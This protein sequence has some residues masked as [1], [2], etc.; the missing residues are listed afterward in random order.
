M[1]D[2][3]RFN[4]HLIV[5]RGIGSICAASYS[6]S[7]KRFVKATGIEQPTKDDVINYLMGF[8]TANKSYSHITNTTLALERYMEFLGTPI[9]LGRPHKPKRIV[10]GTLTEAE[11]ARMF[12]V[13]RNIR[14]RALL[15]ILAYTGIRNL[16]L[17]NL[18]VKDIDFQNNTVFIKGG[19]GQKDGIVCISSDCLAV[20][21]EYLQEYPRKDDETLFCT[22]ARNKK[23]DRLHTSAIRKFIKQLAKRAG[24][25]KRVWPHLFRHSLAMN[26]LMKGCDIYSIREQLR[27]SYISTTFI[28]IHS[29]PKIMQNKYQVFCPSYM[30]EATKDPFIIN[31]NQYYIKK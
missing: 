6:G 7:V 28:Y 17:C 8:Y 20:I 12:S 13:C 1:I 19:K 5:E 26:M 22:I 11:I 30:W 10:V 18:P 15:G 24:I 3:I 29:N 14:E 31:N 9:K 25:Q 21:K 27:H 23:H 4:S 16:E 2:Y